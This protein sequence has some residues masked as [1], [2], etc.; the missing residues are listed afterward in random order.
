M[1]P[2]E[3]SK[4]FSASATADLLRTS[5][6]RKRY[7]PRHLYSLVMADLAK[8]VRG[9]RSKPMFPNL[10]AFLR[11]RMAI[12][13]A[14]YAGTLSADDYSW[15]ADLISTATKAAST[16]ATT[17]LQLDTQKKLTELQTQS[18][19]LSQQ[20]LDLQ[21]KNMNIQAAVAEGLPRNI[22]DTVASAKAG[23]PMV[24]GIPVLPVAVG[25]GVLALVGIYFLVRR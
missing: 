11:T 19:L 17:K 9:D 21:A 12:D 7:S 23:T 20:A 2:V 3:F 18:A 10:R 1:D 16:Y 25:A 4:A 24:G 13:E 15:I 5:I 22:A 8:E 6:L 14:R